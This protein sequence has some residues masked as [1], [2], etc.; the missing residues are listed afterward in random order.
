MQACNPSNTQEVKE[1]ESQ[2]Q[3]PAWA[4]VRPCLKKERKKERKERK[5]KERKGKERKGKERKGRWGWTWWH[6]AMIPYW[7]I[8]LEE[9]QKS[10]ASLVYTG[11]RLVRATSQK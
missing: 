1:G 11:G 7:E 2:T 10:E 3:R 4:I 9:F 6:M 5:G 8:K